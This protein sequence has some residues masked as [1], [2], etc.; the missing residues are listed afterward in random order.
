MRFQ[1]VRDPKSDFGKWVVSKEEYPINKFQPYFCRGLAYLMSID[2]C[3]SLYS[4]VKYADFLW[5][6]DVY[7]TGIVAT[8]AHVAAQNWPGAFN[9][10][11]SFDKH[12]QVY[13]DWKVPFLRRPIF[14]HIPDNRSVAVRQLWDIIEADR[15]SYL[16]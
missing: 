7:I 15:K 4:S 14:T 10:S 9:L 1:Q 13:S 2:V 3:V 16:V 11:L 12:V 6:D 5:L 8:A